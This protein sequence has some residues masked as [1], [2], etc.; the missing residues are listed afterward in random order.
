[1]CTSDS[2][3]WLERSDADPALD[4]YH[5]THLSAGDGDAGDVTVLPRA[6]GRDPEVDRLMRSYRQILSEQQFGD[7]R[8]FRFIRLLGK[9]GQG[10]VF[11]TRCHGADGF[12][13]LVALKIFCPGTYN[14]LEHYEAAMRQIASV[15]SLVARVYHDHLV[16]V[17]RIHKRDGIRLMLMEWIDGYDLRRLTHGRML[18]QFRTIAS[19]EEWDK[20]NEVVVTS[21]PEQSRLHPGAAITIVRD[22]LDGL[23]ILHRMGILH[24]D[25]KP[26]N[27]MLRR[28]GRSKIID[29]GSAVISRDPPA[30]RVFT[31][32]Y[33]APEVL[34][35]K[36]WT[37]QSDLASLGYVVIELLAGRRLF[38]P[39]ES[40][41]ELIVR[42][43]TLPAQLPQLLP[44]R[45]T[46][47]QRLM[48]FLLRLVA[49]D[50]QERFMSA[51]QA[52]LD[53]KNGAYAFLQE[54]ARGGLDA[55]WRN[56]LAIW[57]D[58][59]KG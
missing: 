1:M 56:D 57:V 20:I 25:L 12:Y 23:K 37:P 24:G 38:P 45:V 44:H 33:A 11:L 29:F 31:P 46:R 4:I 51:E 53:P 41:E 2:E 35:R 52:D 10:R 40:V 27:I 42:K 36:Q 58:R 8:T 15:A 14:R 43:Q 49:I 13:R 50:P 32:A 28:G 59:L 7:R 22:C 30:Q 17:Q 18:E 3:T 55:E 16:D 9:G 34:S 26:A 47:S 21:G 39:R 5:S 6:E 48:D 19:N 54:L